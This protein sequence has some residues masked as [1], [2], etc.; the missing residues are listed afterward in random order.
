MFKKT[1][2]SPEP[3]PR[4]AFTRPSP[5]ELEFDFNET[6]PSLKAASSKAVET[7]DRIIKKME[8]L[9][10][11]FFNGLPEDYHSKFP[12]LKE[13]LEEMNL[14][15]VIFGVFAPQ[16]FEQHQNSILVIKKLF[17]IV[18]FDFKIKDNTNPPYL[19]YL[20]K[21]RFLSRSSNLILSGFAELGLNEKA[22]KEDNFIEK[23]FSFQHLVKKFP[24]ESKILIFSLFYI[25]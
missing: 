12:K 25:I 11:P 9:A 22:E 1:V 2:S 17:P 5:T 18:D 23:L 7:D 24:I 14:Y 6:I 19:Y 13:L 4:V 16:S 8:I 15:G 10:A 20:L 21:E 3:T